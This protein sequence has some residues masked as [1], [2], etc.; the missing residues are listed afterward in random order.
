[1]ASKLYALSFFE[2]R[3]YGLVFAILL[4]F[5]SVGGDLNPII[6]L[7]IY[8]W[9]GILYSMSLPLFIAIIC[10]VPLFVGLYF[11][12][13][14]SDISD[15]EYAKLLLITDVSETEKVNKFKISDLKN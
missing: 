9:F 14:K 4:A 15:M 6:S 12:S 7:K 8:D 11:E 13:D 1:M 5:H 3:E 10:C 2:K